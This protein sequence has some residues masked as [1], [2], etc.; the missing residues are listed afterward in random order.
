MRGS[1]LALL[2]LVC[3]AAIAVVVFM[4]QSEKGKTSEF[5]ESD[6]VSE[7]ASDGTNSVAPDPDAD[8]DGTGLISASDAATQHAAPKHADAGNSHVVPH[9]APLKFPTWPTPKAALVITGEQLGY[10]EPCGCTANQLG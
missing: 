4:V 8:G 3:A 10:F 1:I 9:A 7:S 2:S 5:T 6:K